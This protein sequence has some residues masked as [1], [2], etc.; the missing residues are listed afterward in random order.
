MA[1]AS[2]S[3]CDSA[4]YFRIFNPYLQTQKFD[5][6]FLYIKK[7]VPEFQEFTYPAPIVD[8][9]F[10]RKR[11]LGAYSEALKKNV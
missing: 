8:H 11:C 1:A 4:P 7:W 5:A 9:A 3:G 6:D 10:A 2:G